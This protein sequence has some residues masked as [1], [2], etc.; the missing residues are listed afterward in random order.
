MKTPSRV[1]VEKVFHDVVRSYGG[2]VL[3]DK[4]PPSPNFQ[5]ADYVFHFEK[6]VAELKCLSLDNTFSDARQEKIKRLLMQ[7]C[8][9]GK[10]ASNI[11]DET[12]F[13]TFPPDVQTDIYHI[14]TKNIRHCIEKA[15]KQIRTTKS[16]LN[17]DD[18]SGLLII[19]NDGVPSLSPAMFIHATQMA[20][21]NHF[22][23]IRH[24]IYLT[25]NIFT[26]LRETPLPT[27]FWIGFD[28]EDG[29]KIDPILLERLRKIWIIHCQRAQGVAGVELEI[30]DIE[31]FWNAHHI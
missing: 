12:T 17:L 22:H 4:L 5:N 9:E 31:G 13:K 21:K 18:Y 30:N 19:A 29:E 24:F 11:F 10:I 6:V 3:D 23:E 2:V 28:M 27:L 20:L 14:L 15:N 1:N 26:S 16:E 7:K 8:S 25:A